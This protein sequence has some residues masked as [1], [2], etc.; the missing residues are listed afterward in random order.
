[1]SRNLT[2]LQQLAVEAIQEDERLT[3]GLS[4]DQAGALL[5]WATAKAAELARAAADE[6]AVEALAQAI[7]QAVRAAARAD[8]SVTRAEQTL[9][10]AIPDALKPTPAQGMAQTMPDAPKSPAQVAA[11]PATLLTT[12]ATAA[13]LSMAFGASISPDPS[14]PSAPL[15]VMPQRPSY[16]RR[17]PEALPLSLLAHLGRR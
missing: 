17:W 9:A 5:K 7:R 1:M 14:D 8:G 16:A 6:S 4:D 13:P 3:A 2:P 11:P 12:S 10:Q 15:S